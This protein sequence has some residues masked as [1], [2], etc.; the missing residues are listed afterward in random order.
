MANVF[1]NSAFTDGLTG[2]TASLATVTTDSA[3]G[4]AARLPGS[5]V[6]SQYCGDAELSSGHLR[7]MLAPLDSQRLGLQIRF[8]YT[9]GHRTEAFVGADV[10]PFTVYPSDPATGYY[11]SGPLLGVAVAVDQT[12]LLRSFLLTNFNLM[13]TGAVAVSNFILLGE[14]SDLNGDGGIPGGGLFKSGARAHETWGTRMFALER[15]LDSIIE[16]LDGKGKP[17]KC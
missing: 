13:E 4:P 9:D 10:R 3:L 14:R 8:E 12:R 2:W 7:F 1:L 15:R 6:I 17:A 16:R 11:I 5:A